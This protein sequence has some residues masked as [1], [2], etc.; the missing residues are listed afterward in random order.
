M[1]KASSQFAQVKKA[2]AEAQ[3]SLAAISKEQ[4]EMDGRG[5]AQGSGEDFGLRAEEARRRAPLPRCLHVRRGCSRQVQSPAGWH[6][7]EET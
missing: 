2:V 3:K 4:A 5:F 6:H 1:D 7:V